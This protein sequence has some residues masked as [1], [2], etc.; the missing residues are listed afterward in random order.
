MRMV[1]KTLIQ[2]ITSEIEDLERFEINPNFYAHIVITQILKAPHLA[3][4]NGNREAGLTSLIFGV[5][6]LE[7]ICKANKYVEDGYDNDIKKE[8]SKLTDKDGLVKDA[9]IANIKLQELLR[10][11]FKNRMHRIDL[12]I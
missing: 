11:V 5:D 4:I 3:F 2:S 1:E 6:Q 10:Y 8:I 12:I 9:K 7:R